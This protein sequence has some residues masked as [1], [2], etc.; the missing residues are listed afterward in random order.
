MPRPYLM[1]LNQECQLATSY[2]VAFHRLGYSLKRP[3][4]SLM[5]GTEYL[6]SQISKH[7]GLLALMTKGSFNRVL[8]E[9][10]HEV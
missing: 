3:H 6:L 9:V 5:G 1:G 2:H 8:V 10:E 4:D 7:E